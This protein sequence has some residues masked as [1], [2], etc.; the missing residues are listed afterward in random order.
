MLFLLLFVLY[1]GELTPDDYLELERN[2]MQ[3]PTLA[4][5][6]DSMRNI[7]INYPQIVN[8]DS[9][10][11]SYEGRQILYLEIS[12]QPG[13]DEGEVGLFFIG[14]H[15]G[16][17]WTSVV[18]PLFFADSLVSAYGQD[19]LI[20]WIVDNCRIWIMPCFNV[21]GY[22][23]SH[24]LGNTGWRKNRR[25]YGG[26]IGI[27][28]NRNYYGGCSG[29]AHDTWGGQPHPNTSHQ[30]SNM[31]FCGPAAFSEYENQALFSF[32][33]TQH[34]N[35]CISYH[36]YGE[37]VS[38]PW[39]WSMN[40]A[41][42]GALLEIMC[43]TIAYLITR[44]SGSGHYTSFQQSSWYQICGSMGDFMYGFN[45][46]VRGIPCY[47]F[48]VELGTSL[49]PD[50]SYLPQICHE[51][52]KALLYLAQHLDSVVSVTPRIIIAPEIN[53]QQSGNDFTVYWIPQ[54]DVTVNFWRLWQMMNMDVIIDTF[55]T[56]NPRWSLS[57]FSPSTQQA[58]SGNYSILANYLDGSIAHATTRHPH[59]VEPGDTASFWTYYDLESN[60]D[61]AFFEISTDGLV[62][63]Q[64]FRLTGQQTYWQSRSYPLEE[65]TGKSLYFRFRLST[66]GNNRYA[67]VYI[68]D[69]SP[70]VDYDSI[71]LGPP[72]PDTFQQFTN[73]PQGT[74]FYRAQGY[75]N[76][77]PGIQSQLTR[78]DVPVAIAEIEP[79]SIT[80]NSFFPTVSRRPQLKAIPGV[81]IYNILGQKIEDI[82][83]AGI[84]FVEKNQKITKIIIID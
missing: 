65:Y 20:T 53:Y 11:E 29:S 2:R 76:Q 24:D 51:N 18:V 58:H 31:F 33:N 82:K 35:T 17:E 46:Y 61:V 71:I 8:L 37:S 74:Y 19:S 32:L 44:Q 66:D 25:P 80:D 59:L 40:P 13:I 9:I 72:R 43:D 38:R 39:A 54:T 47:P 3:Y 34:I 64:I 27:D 52:F 21:D 84:Y 16:N 62:W 22:Y 15:H 75:N 56:T 41:P 6:H 12:D 68:D 70:T 45:R 69:F 48:T 63:D 78:V 55:G 26:S 36:C 28:P 79:N 60:G 50:T 14:L 7:A 57:G 81:K 73:M 49:A 5:L 30:P 23:F 77:G 4:E 83:K 10:G 1:D 67:G 42:D